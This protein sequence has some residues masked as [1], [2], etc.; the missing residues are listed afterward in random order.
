MARTAAHQYSRVHVGKLILEQ[1][2]PV[3]EATRSI[4]H[5]DSLVRFDHVSVSVG[6]LFLSSLRI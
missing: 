1:G 2:W 4:D 6:K 3:N 5:N